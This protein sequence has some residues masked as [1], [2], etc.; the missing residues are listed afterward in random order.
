MLTRVTTGGRRR[1]QKQRHELW[2]QAS[3]QCIIQPIKWHHFVCVKG[4]LG[5]DW[6]ELHHEQR[7]AV[8]EDKGCD[9]ITF[10]RKPTLLPL[11]LAGDGASCSQL[12]PSQT[13]DVISGGNDNHGDDDDEELNKGTKKDDPASLI[14]CFNAETESPAC[15][16][17]RKKGKKPSICIKWRRL[18]RTP[19]AAITLIIY[20]Q[21]GASE[22]NWRSSGRRDEGAGT[23]LS[24]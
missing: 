18:P 9:I 3:S 5:E 8:T 6:L 21:I 11:T 4:D 23:R 12:D 16:E 14:G 24:V 17:K 22:S 2:F 7:A 15:H 19:S 1:H 10:L 20:L 13:H